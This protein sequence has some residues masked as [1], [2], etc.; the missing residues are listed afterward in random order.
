MK[1]ISSEITAEDSAGE[2]CN[3][4]GFALTGRN[5]RVGKGTG[6][7]CIHNISLYNYSDRFDSGLQDGA[8]AAGAR[9]KVPCFFNQD[10]LSFHLINYPPNYS[11]G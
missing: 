3:I 7:N 4:M 2:K 10:S 5:V 6:S 8:S 9:V 11:G 1:N